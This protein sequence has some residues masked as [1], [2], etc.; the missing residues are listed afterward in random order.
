LA[1]ENRHLGNPLVVDNGGRLAG[2]G[3]FASATIGAGSALAPGWAGAA[4]IGGLGFSH[5]ELNSG[6]ILEWHIQNPNGESGVGFDR[7]HVYTEETLVINATAG[8]PFSLRII[9]LASG[10]SAGL[11]A[12]LT[13]GA[14][15]SWMLIASD[16]TTGTFD[17]AKFALD[18]SQFQTSLGVGLDAGEFSVSLSGNN[19]MLNF[20][21]VPEPSTY[22][23]MA[24][25]LGVIGWSVWRRR[26]A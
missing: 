1:L 23:L 17:P 5:L 18:V 12:G 26:K 4:E 2:N 19:L 22:A 14:S 3:S 20:T 7:I 13:P 25:G 10:G 9:S 24:L 8:S 11:L 6:G 16:S 21:A 15:Y